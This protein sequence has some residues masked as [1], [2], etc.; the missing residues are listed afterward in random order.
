MTES[1][2]QLLGG[3]LDVSR[4]TMQKL[5]SFERIFDQWSR[6]INLVAA[7]TTNQVWERHIADSAQLML[8]KPEMK[9]VVDLGSGGGFPG[10]VLAILLDQLEGSRVDLVESNRKK[11]AFLQ[12]AR[13]S[14]APRAHI[15]AK[16]I[17]DALPTIPTPEC[18]TAR[19]LASLSKLFELA[20]QHLTDGA[21]GLFHKGRGFSLELEE[22]RANWQF[23]LITH[24]SE[25]DA[26][27]VVLEIRNLRRISN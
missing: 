12:A 6:K 26:D 8:L 15:H 20:E 14:C 1:S 24:Q 9:T 16:R 11:T 3:A 7:S 22:S 4:E 17:E 21:I 18:V 27:S 25:I 5:S 2:S 23:D 10:I 19:A 13:A